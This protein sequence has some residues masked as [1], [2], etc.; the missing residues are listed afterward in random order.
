MLIEENLIFRFVYGKE[1]EYNKVVWFLYLSTR[2]SF[3]SCYT[4]TLLKD[5]FSSFSICR[6]HYD[7]QNGISRQSSVYF[8]GSIMTLILISVVIHF[9]SDLSSK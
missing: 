7:F 1:F 9:Y 4:V 2:I 5:F 3:S 6:F 8:K